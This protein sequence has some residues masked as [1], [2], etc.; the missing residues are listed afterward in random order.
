MKIQNWVK[1]GLI[2]RPKKKKWNLTHCMLPTPIK[3]TEN[4]FKIFF[5]SRN[6]KNQSSIG[7]VDI[8][9]KKRVLKF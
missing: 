2:I 3:L 7:S 6:D 5:G 4:K 1:L 9:F 8:L